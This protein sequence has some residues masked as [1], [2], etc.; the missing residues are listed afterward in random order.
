MLL[1]IYLKQPW[2]RKIFDTNIINFFVR[3]ADATNEDSLV[4]KKISDFSIF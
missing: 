2:T 3:L 1:Q 4:E